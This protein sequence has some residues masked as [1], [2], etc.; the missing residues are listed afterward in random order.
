MTQLNTILLQNLE[1]RLAPRPDTPPRALNERFEVRS[2]L[3]H[4]KQ[5]NTFART[6][7]A[8][9]ECFLL[10]MQHQEL[11][12]HDRAHPAGA[13]ARDAC[14]INARFA[15]IRS[16]GCCSCTSCSSRAASCTSS[17]A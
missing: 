2:E 11:R 12:G 6:P 13:V 5:E 14:S 17:A 8:I 9:L 7:S 4:I 10:M 15:E 1:A 16:R 3:L